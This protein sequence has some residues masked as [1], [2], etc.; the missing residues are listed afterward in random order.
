M[1]LFRSKGKTALETPAPADFQGPP[2]N[3]PDNSYNNSLTSSNLSSADTRVN[4]NPQAPKTVVTTTT[5]TT[6]TTTVDSDGSTRT[7]THPYNPSVDPPPATEVVQ[8]NEDANGVRA[9]NHETERPGLRHSTSGGR[10]IPP[11]SELRNAHISPQPLSQTQPPHHHGSQPLAS[12]PQSP[13]FQESTS[14]PVTPTSPSSSA[15]FSRPLGTHSSRLTNAF[16][17]LHGAGEAIRGTLN[18]T[19]AKGLGD[20]ADMERQRDIKEQGLREVRDSGF[21]DKAQT[22]LRRRSASRELKSGMV[23]GRLERVD[24]RVVN[25]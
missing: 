9:F 14:D 19:V 5:T 6:T 24:E 1:G 2:S 16:K 23:D 17:G 4:N 22:R 18:S 25:I 11:R 15:N 3:S 7:Q 12:H 13:T 21:R 10:P 20:D 8:T